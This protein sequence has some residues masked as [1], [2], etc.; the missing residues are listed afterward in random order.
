MLLLMLSSMRFSALQRAE[1]SSTAR[2]TRAASR[3]RWFQC[4]SASRKFLNRTLRPTLGAPRAV[5][6]LFSEPK[7]PQQIHLVG[8]RR[9]RP[10]FQCSSASRKFLNSQRS[11]STQTTRGS[12][13]VLFSEPKIPQRGVCPAREQRRSGFSALQRAE[14][15][16]TP[17]TCFFRNNKIS[18]FSALQRAENSSTPKMLC[19][20]TV[21]DTEFQCSSASR[22]FLNTGCRDCGRGR[23]R[24]FSALQRAENSSTPAS[25]VAISRDRQKFQCSS[26]SRKFLNTRRRNRRRAGRAS[27]FSA[28]QRAENSSTRA[29]RHDLP[30]RVAS[31]LFSE[32]KIPQHFAGSPL[33]CFEETSQCSSASRKFL[34]TPTLAPA[35]IHIPDCDDHASSFLSLPGA[36]P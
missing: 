18:S 21:D 31:V 29:G 33:R 12:V 23:F 16:S 30:Q 25:R 1:N 2:A 17:N 14:N 35:S 9:Q 15:S 26:A 28:L 32:P 4:S 8:E 13:S 34:N 27:G 7:I 20:D 10:R 11:I 36:S 5:S 3:R 24:R 19:C 22:K 6:V